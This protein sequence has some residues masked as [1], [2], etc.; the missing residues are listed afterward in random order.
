MGRGD[1]AGVGGAR[2]IEFFYKESKSNF[3]FLFRMWGR[4]LELLIFLQ[5]M[6]IFFFFFFL[7]GGGVHGWEEVGVEGE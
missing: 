4:G 3:F 7:G 6:K 1:G 2:V 5:S